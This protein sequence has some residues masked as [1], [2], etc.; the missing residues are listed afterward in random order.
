MTTVAAKRDVLLLDKSDPLEEKFFYWENG[1][2]KQM[3]IHHADLLIWTGE[4]KVLAARGV[5][6]ISRSN[7]TIRTHQLRSV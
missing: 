2:L 5:Q 1:Q 6:A 4:S 3:P 7:R